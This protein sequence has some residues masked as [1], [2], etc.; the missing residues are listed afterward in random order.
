MTAYIRFVYSTL[1]T[2]FFRRWQ[3]MI[4]Y[5]KYLVLL[6][7]LIFITFSTNNNAQSALPHFFP[8]GVNQPASPA[9]QWQEWL[10]YYNAARH[11]LADHEASWPGFIQGSDTIVLE[12]E[13]FGQK[14]KVIFDNYICEGR[15]N[16]NGCDG[17]IRYQSFDGQ[18]YVTREQFQVVVSMVDDF[19]VRA[20]EN[21][22]YPFWGDLEKW[23]VSAAA[24]AEGETEDDFRKYLDRE[25]SLNP[26]ITFRELRH[27]P[28]KIE[29]K[30]FI[31]YREI[32]FGLTPDFPEVLGVAWL[33]AGVIHYTPVAMI[34]DY[35]LKQPEVLAHEFVHANTKLQNM[36]L[37]WGFDLEFNASIAEMLL[38]NDHLHLWNH[39]YAV[40]FREFVQ[41]F[42]G[43]KFDQARDEIVKRTAWM[44]MGHVV[45]DEDKFNEYSMK[46]NLGKQALKD[47]LKTGTQW[48]YSN[49]LYWSAVNDKT[50][51]DNFVFR[52]VMSAMYNPTLLGGE[53]ATTRWRE[54]HK[55]E[56]KQMI[57]KAWEDSGKPS[58][59]IQDTL[60][61]R[62]NIR[63]AIIF[64]EIQKTYGISDEEV[65]KFLRANRVSSL[66]DLLSWEPARLKRSIDDFLKK[67]RKERG[68]Q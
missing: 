11:A 50:V 65:Q 59:G 28:E 37:G 31:P 26:G 49:P 30:D 60:E 48:L 42:F 34:M 66:T 5:N 1:D 54:T 47:A 64:G 62:R 46:L 22:D 41:V 57:D 56:I 12:K 13:Y 3:A 17:K 27:I 38:E 44:S 10:R 61:N 20:V 45:I 19:A 23:A 25:D 53:E 21:I 8:E 68:L 55:Y 67:E 7:I 52:V 33:N 15:V 29:K 2:D 51:D 32:H 16:R 6:S 43:F 39:S 9:R 63:A 40:D 18:M 24:K 14:T 36:P 35:I 58:E 4:F